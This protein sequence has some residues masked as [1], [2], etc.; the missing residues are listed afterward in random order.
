VQYLLCIITIRD[1][2]GIIL[3]TFINY[4]S[5]K[6]IIIFF[7]LIIF[8]FSLLFASILAQGADIDQ[9]KQLKIFQ[10]S[11]L[12]E[13]ENEFPRQNS[14]FKNAL[15]YY[16]NE[17]Y[18]M[19]INELEKIEYSNLHIPLYLRSQ[20]LKG[21]AYKKL[22]R[23]ESVVYIYQNLYEN[24]PLMQDYSAYYLAKTYLSMGDT[25]SAIELFQE[26][27]QDYPDSALIPR[28]RYQNAL[29][30]LE[31]GYLDYFLE[32]CNMAIDTALETKFKAI[33]LTRMIDVLW[34]NGQFI[35]SL[36][37]LKDLI[38]NRYDPERAAGF[39]NLF[40]QRYQLA[41]KNEN[42]E[43]PPDLLLFCAGIYFN[44]RQ[45]EVAET[46]YD[47]V[48]KLYPDQVDLAQVY[49]NKARAIHYQGE[50]ERAIEQCIYILENFQEPEDI[51]IKTM[52]LYA[53]GLLSSGN[54]ILAL[55]KYREIIERYPKSYFAPSSYLRL[56]EIEFLQERKKEGVEILDRLIADY[57]KSS[58]AS[59]ASWKLARYYT[60]RDDNNSALQY[61]KVICDNFSESSQGDDALYWFGKLQASLD[62]QKG[63]QA[64]KMLLDK[65]PDSYYIFRL[66]AEIKLETRNINEIISD[67]K[68]ISLTEFKNNYIPVDKDAQLAIY[69]AELLKTIGIYQESAVEIINALNHE[70]G[71]VYLIYLLTELYHQDR[72]YYRS[73]G[74]AQTLLD[75]FLNDDRIE[76][77]PF[78]I[79]QY[80]FPDNYFSTITSRA[81]DYSLDPFLVLATI[82]EES[83]FNRYSESR[84]GARG[85]MQIVL[86]TGEWIAQKLN[87]QNFDYD[88]LFE[89]DVNIHFGCWYLNYL[90]EKYNRN[91]YLMISG[92][93]AGP[94]IT[95][96]WLE[97]FDIN[98]IDSFVENIPYPETTEHIKKVM[99][100]YNIYKII[101]DN[102]Q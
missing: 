96:K 38:E 94:G 85:L 98:D 65:Y 62:R 59:E 4:Q 32:E 100:A 77:M 36:T 28:V 22:Q 24:I 97:Q 41:R 26:I 72:E 5:N 60:N 27:V 7:F 78:K 3:T 10:L 44:Y 11:H 68:K 40:V 89:P 56:S 30:Y 99:R 75:Y 46:L 74:W 57:P 84:A 55:E 66:P 70:S 31:E 43:M 52:Y 6:K 61:Y 8:F 20:L 73:I 33:V 67:S 102:L 88:L 63:W 54:R 17:H 49:Y 2:G 91:N 82:K 80:V 93:N 87:Y 53:G 101:Y 23:W 18:G 25:K 42:I 35:N 71:N 47:E 19:A 51:I 90:Q 13:A 12:L 45:Y 76:E 21:Q 86:S 39:E 1:F 81:S 79:W 83:H 34:E 64:Y 48:I 92:Y 29:I 9:E 14:Y 15:A 95:D 58:Q 50:Y 16:K 69:K 37:Y